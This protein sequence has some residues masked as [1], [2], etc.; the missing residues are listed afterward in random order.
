M[1]RVLITVTM[2]LIGLLTN[3]QVSES[4]KMTGFKDIEV[5]NGIT[6]IY[7]QSSNAS[8]SVKAD[9][10]AALTGI[11]TERVGSTLKIYREA[12]EEGYLKPEKH[13]NFT[14]YVLADNLT[15]L[16]AKSG[17]CIKVV[18]E[19]KANDFTINLMGGSSFKGVIN[20]V[21]KCTLYARAGSSF[22]GMVTADSFMGDFR[23]GSSIKICG[24]ANKADITTNTGASCL[25]ER[26]MA[27]TAIM[28]AKNGSSI[29]LA[30]KDSVFA[31]ADA[32]SSATYYG[33]PA[34]TAINK[35]SYTVRK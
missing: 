15:G 34:V 18:S 28:D 10:K 24:N 21:G 7:T 35:N 32:S 20:T 5:Q 9:S 26:F 3:A 11:V 14:V 6:L 27:V 12:K 4:R 16:T 13:S 29:F 25:A 17:A 8:I 19:I 33:S 1:V 31:F 30:V 23:N 22:N 2:T